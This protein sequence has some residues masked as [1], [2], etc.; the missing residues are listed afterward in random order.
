MA[1]RAYLL[2]KLSDQVGRDEAQ[3]ALRQV[4]AMPEVDFADPTV[5]G[6]D[7]VLMVE[8]ADSVGALADQVAKFPW[9]RTLEVLKIASSFE[10]HR[11]AA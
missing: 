3:R 10:R 9:V 5:G 7:L 11:A 1:L 6:Y 4:E 8:T 2:I